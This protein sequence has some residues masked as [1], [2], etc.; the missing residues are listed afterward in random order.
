MSFL[1]V[2]KFH[3][4]FKKIKNLILHSCWPSECLFSLPLSG[5]SARTW[6]LRCGILSSAF[7][8]GCRPIRSAAVIPPAFWETSSPR[9]TIMS[10]SSCFKGEWGSGGKVSFLPAG[11]TGPRPRSRQ[12]VSDSCCWTWTHQPVKCVN[13]MLI[14]RDVNNLFTSRLLRTI[15][16]QQKNWVHMA[17]KWACQLICSHTISQLSLSSLNKLKVQDINMTFDCVVCSFRLVPFLTELRAVMD[18]VWTDTSLSLSSWICVEDIYAHIFILKCW[19]ES[20]KVFFIVTWKE[21]TSEPNPVMLE[22]RPS[23]YHC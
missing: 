9:A 12:D 15:L 5:D 14:T 4:W 19:R 3:L 8:S 11:Q 17:N 22:F 7:T 23:I 13:K 20:E 6:S 10:T 2:C 18:W 1:C 21:L 16:K